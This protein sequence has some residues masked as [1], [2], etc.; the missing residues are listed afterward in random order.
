MGS[1]WGIRGNALDLLGLS[2][3]PVSQYLRFKITG[4]DPTFA[5]VYLEVWYL[6]ESEW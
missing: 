3:V 5:F 6:R 2:T 1:F 4:D